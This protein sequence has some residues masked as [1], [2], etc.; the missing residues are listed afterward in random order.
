MYYHIAYDYY[1]Y[2]VRLLLLTF[3][4]LTS[5]RSKNCLSRKT[6]RRKTLKTHQILLCYYS[7]LN[8][9]IPFSQINPNYQKIIKN[10][11]GKSCRRL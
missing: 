11:H 1:I 5:E 2:H 4:K 6:S 9:I 3:E 10:R 7:F 8:A